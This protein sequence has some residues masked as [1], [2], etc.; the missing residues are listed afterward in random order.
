MYQ[1]KLKGELLHG[2]LLT[3]YVDDCFWMS[4]MDASSCNFVEFML[5]TKINRILPIKFDFCIFTYT[6]RNSL[7]SSEAK[8]FGGTVTPSYRR[9]QVNIGKH[10]KITPGC[11]SLSK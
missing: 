4:D 2:Y 3:L 11:Y 9:F 6:E 10:Q 8:T 1:R 7:L 5:H